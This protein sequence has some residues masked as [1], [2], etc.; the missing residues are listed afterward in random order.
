MQEGEWWEF[1]DLHLSFYLIWCCRSS[2]HTFLPKKRWCLPTFCPTCYQKWIPRNLWFRFRSLTTLFWNFEFQIWWS[3]ASYGDEFCGCFNPPLPRF[4][5][6]IHRWRQRGHTAKWRQRSQFSGAH[7]QLQPSSRVDDLESA[8]M[9]MAIKRVCTD[10]ESVILFLKIML[11]DFAP[12]GLKFYLSISGGW[13]K[14][15]FHSG[16][17][18]HPFQSL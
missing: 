5:S 8:K 11:V 15:S 1:A 13:H 10:S 2:S 16:L 14:E 12:L 7:V 6:H 9:D 18:H 17:F 3:R 4:H